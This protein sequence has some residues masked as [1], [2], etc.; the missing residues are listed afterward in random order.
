MCISESSIEVGCFDTLDASQDA[1]MTRMVIQHLTS[2][3][4]EAGFD[5]PRGVKMMRRGGCVMGDE[6]R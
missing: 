2:S 1:Q 3:P 4:V 6:I 5:A